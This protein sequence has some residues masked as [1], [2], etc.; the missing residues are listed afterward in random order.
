MSVQQQI[1]VGLRRLASTIGICTAANAQEQVRALLDGA[2]NR[3][4]DSK[5]R[6]GHR[7]HHYGVETTRRAFQVKRLLNAAGRALA[8]DPSKALIL[9]EE[10]QQAWNPPKQEA[11][12][13][14]AARS[15]VEPL[16]RFWG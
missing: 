7:T 14:F 16:R 5:D 15:G 11:R 4:L 10:A 6:R 3:I 2:L 8:H 13:T 12:L 9:V 1:D